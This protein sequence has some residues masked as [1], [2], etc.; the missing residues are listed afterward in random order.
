MKINL[1]IADVRDPALGSARTMTKLDFE[2]LFQELRVQA[3]GFL[4]Q[5]GSLPPTLF[6]PSMGAEGIVRMG[7]MPVGDLVNH[8]VGKDILSMLME[9]LIEDPNHDF[10][11][12]FHEAWALHANATSPDEVD[13]LRSA[14]RQSLEHHP[15]RTEA[16]VISIR[17]K[18]AQAFAIMPIARDAS[19][20]VSDLGH[21][22]LMFAGEDGHT[23]EG[24]FAAPGRPPGATVH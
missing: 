2:A 20:A 22:E 21:G 17:S 3:A 16:V 23:M 13:K 7:V 4:A 1:P 15:D 12:F 6:L 9:R 8:P 14:A 10:V 24:R 18:D 11:A 5:A 19:G